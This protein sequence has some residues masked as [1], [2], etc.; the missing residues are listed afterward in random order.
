MTENA[1][2]GFGD[3]LQTWLP[4]SDW[5]RSWSIG[6]IDSSWPLFQKLLLRGDLLATGS[7]DDVSI[8][9][10]EPRLWE[11]LKPKCR[12]LRNPDEAL[13]WQMYGAPDMD[14]Y[15]PGTEANHPEG[16]PPSREDLFPDGLAPRNIGD[17]IH[18]ADV[19]SVF[20]IVDTSAEIRCVRFR[21]SVKNKQPVRPALAD[22][23]QV[24]YRTAAPGRP[25]SMHLVENELKRRAESG[26]LEATLAEQARVLR[27]WLGT[28]HP[29]AVPPTEKTIRNRIRSGFRQAMAKLDG[30]SAPRRRSR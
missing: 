23:D 15:G 7:R 21:R 11:R 2:L 28:A 26:R 10:I 16:H 27:D 17:S 19:E 9:P 29:D 8:V 6:H 12:W 1:D 14:K 13:A 5:D 30:K 18:D 20:R 25:S 24:T 22:K 3:A 4:K